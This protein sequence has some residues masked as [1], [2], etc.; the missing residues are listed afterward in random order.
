MITT[1]TTRSSF[2]SVEPQK[3]VPQPAP[4]PGQP[5]TPCVKSRLAPYFPKGTLDNIRVQQ[6]GM[7]AYVVGDPL[8]YTEENRIYFKPGKYDP[9][10]VQ[11]LSD[12]GHEI[13]HKAQYDSLGSATFQKRYLQEYFELRQLGFD[14]Q[15]AYENIS[16]EVEARKRADIIKNDLTNLMRDFG[17]RDPC[18]K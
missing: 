3:P 4:D 12:I 6:G 10:S 15:T 11:G 8:A 7:P 5:L 16:F 13:T 9:H 1:T 14:H 2:L 18:P 17:G